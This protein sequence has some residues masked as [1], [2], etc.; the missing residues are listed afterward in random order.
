MASRIPSASARASASIDKIA[1][2]CC[3][4]D[5]HEIGLLAD[6][7]YPAGDLFS[8]DF[9]ISPVKICEA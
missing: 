1:M 2:L 8:V 7:E 6:F 3:F 4:L 5:A 9:T